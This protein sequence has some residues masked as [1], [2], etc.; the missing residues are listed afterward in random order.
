MSWTFS[1]GFLVIS[2]K[3]VVLWAD[4]SGQ[5]EES[6]TTVSEFSEMTLDK[7]LPFT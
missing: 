7:L 1:D 2:G 3:S 4:M 5:E 6:K